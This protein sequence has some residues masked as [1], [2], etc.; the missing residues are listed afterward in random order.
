MLSCEAFL[1]TGRNGQGTQSNTGADRILLEG[2]HLFDFVDAEA[3]FAAYRLLILPDHPT[4]IRI[5]THTGNAVPYILY[6]SRRDKGSNAVYTEAAAAATGNCLEE[7]YKLIE[8]LL[9]Q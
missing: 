6:D 4:P 5:R 2:K 3:D 9:E 1:G 7:G 8:K